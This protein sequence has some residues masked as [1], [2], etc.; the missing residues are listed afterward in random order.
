MLIKKIK[1]IQIKIYLCS[2]HN[3]PP[4][5]KT[6]DKGKWTNWPFK[7]A[8]LYDKT[9]KRKKTELKSSALPTIPVTASVW[10]GCTVNIK[11]QSLEKYLNNIIFQYFNRNIFWS[12]QQPLSSKLDSCFFWRQYL[13]F[14]EFVFKKYATKKCYYWP[15]I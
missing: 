15:V 5:T 12:Q 11:L 4:K 6:M 1:C 3:I 2:L 14:Q 10:I 8:F 7:A 9:V 13:T